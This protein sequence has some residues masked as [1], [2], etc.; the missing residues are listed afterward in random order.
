MKMAI[1][2]WLLLAVLFVEMN[3]QVDRNRLGLTCLESADADP[4]LMGLRK[5]DAQ[6][7]VNQSTR[8]AVISIT[9]GAPK[10]RLAAECEQ[11]HQMR[12]L[13]PMV[14]HSDYTEIGHYY[15][16]I[17]SSLLNIFLA[18]HGFSVRQQMHLPDLQPIF[19]R[20]VS[21]ASRLANS[22]AVQERRITFYPCHDRLL[23]PVHPCCLIE[24]RD[25]SAC[26][27]NH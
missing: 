25:N 24:L 13:Q 18:T 21:D 26:T 1:N 11:K 5:S 16:M 7:V 4:I 10:V 12:K 8:D 23:T 14:G 17:R 2:R 20:R 9:G 19:T 6:K 3:T 15:T 27:Q 22:S